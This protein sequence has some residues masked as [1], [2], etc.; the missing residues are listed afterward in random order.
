MRK[1]SIDKSKVHAISGDPDNNSH[2]FHNRYPTL[3]VPGR[4]LRSN[5]IQNCT[6][7]ANGEIL[8]LQAAENRPVLQRVE[9]N[10]ELRRTH[11]MYA[12]MQ[13]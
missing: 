6:L 4:K 9:K 5:L 12:K 2:G 3:F 11:E 7:P 1:T 10:T 8:W 13:G